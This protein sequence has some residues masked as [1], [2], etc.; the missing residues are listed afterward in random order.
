MMPPCEKV[1]EDNYCTMTDLRKQGGARLVLSPVK[2]V[3]DYF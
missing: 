1:Q 3:E 2:N